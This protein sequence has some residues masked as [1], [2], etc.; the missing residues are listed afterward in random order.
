MS[1]PF[2]TDKAQVRAAFERAATRYDSAAV[3]Q[4]EVSDRMAERL[5]YIKVAPPV[6][7]DAGSGTGYGAAALKARYPDARVVE[8]D[9]AHAMLAASRE[10]QKD[11]AGFLGR[12]LKKAPWQVCADIERLP[13]ADESVDMIW[14]NLAIQWVNVPDGVFAEFRRVLKPDGLLMFSTLGPDTLCELRGA[15]AG[16]DGATHV[17]QFIDMH[18]LGDALLS[19]GFATPVMDMEKIVLTYDDARGV[20]QDLKAI[21]AHNVTDGR[22]RGLLGKHAWQGVVERYEAHRRD[23]KLPATYEVVYGHAWKGSPKPK[24]NALPDGRQ[25]IEFVRRGD[26]SR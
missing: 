14:S 21:G 4:R 20:M 12:L 10:K 2:Y 18:D 3:L 5:D 22:R 9:L 19:G 11:G 15:F 7:L 24:G 16:V 13:L 8:L 6:I 1:E 26:A 23:G 25:V 17:N